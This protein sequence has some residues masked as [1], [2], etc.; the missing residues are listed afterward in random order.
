M[1]HSQPDTKPSWRHCGLLH[2]DAVKPFNAQGT[3]VML[4]S[5]P[6]DKLT[7][8]CECR[9]VV[10]PT[11][12][13]RAHERFEDHGSSKQAFTVVM[14]VIEHLA[15]LNVIRWF[16]RHGRLNALDSF[17]FVLDG[18]LAIFGM[19]ALAETPLAGRA[20]TFE[21]AGRRVRWN[22]YSA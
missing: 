1:P 11:D 19:A 12:S 10:Y 16:E 6:T 18:P 3:N 13:L 5:L 22:R 20:I 14:A 17:A 21:Q 15:M 4:K 7:N 9:E 2:P 8:C